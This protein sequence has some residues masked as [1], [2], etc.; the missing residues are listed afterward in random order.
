MAGDYYPFSPQRK[1]TA[2]GGG[3][4]GWTKPKCNATV[5]HRLGLEQQQGVAFNLRRL[6]TRQPIND[7]VVGTMRKKFSGLG[8]LNTERKS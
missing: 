8:M 2:A 3:V 1:K 5:F 6:S 4:D 7:T